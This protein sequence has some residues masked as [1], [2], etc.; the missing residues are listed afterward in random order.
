MT[1]RWP[2]RLPLPTVD[3]YGIRPGEAILRTEMEAG[4]ARQRRRY[5]QVPSRITVRWVLRREQFALFEAARQ[6]VHKGPESDPDTNHH[7][8]NDNW[9][10]LGT[11]LGQSSVRIDFGSH[12]VEVPHHGVEGVPTRACMALM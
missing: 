2:D 9:V 1:N 11:L 6:R 8:S 4:P 3:G 10:V 5:T 12:F 7:L